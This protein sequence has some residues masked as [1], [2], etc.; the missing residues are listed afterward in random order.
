[1]PRPDNAGLQDPP[2]PRLA[3]VEPSGRESRGE[4]VATLPVRPLIVV[5]GAVPWTAGEPTVPVVALQRLRYTVESLPARLSG[6]HVEAP[7]EVAQSQDKLGPPV[8]RPVR[9][10]ERREV[11]DN[12]PTIRCPLR[13]ELRSSQ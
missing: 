10:R 3:N 5:V 2:N 7:Y 13:I 8:D 4:L 11:T 1:M 12:P 6:D 9:Q